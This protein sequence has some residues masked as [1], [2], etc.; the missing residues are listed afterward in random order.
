LNRS[1]LASALAGQRILVV[2]DEMLLAMMVEDLL[3]GLGC[4]VIGPARPSPRRCA[5]R[6][7]NASTASCSI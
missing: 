2:E 6:S 5:L 3:A 1:S 7:R 4:R